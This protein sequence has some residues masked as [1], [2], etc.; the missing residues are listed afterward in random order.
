MKTFL[1]HIKNSIQYPLYDW[2]I[3][4]ILGIIIFLISLLNKISLKNPLLSYSLFIISEVLL[5][6]EMGYG[7]KIVY[8]GI[9]GENKPPLFDKYLN[10]I[11]EGFRKTCIFLTYTSALAFL[12]REAMTIVWTDNSNLILKIVCCLAYCLIYL[13]LIGSI[14]NRYEHNGKFITAFN[15]KEIYEL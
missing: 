14:L 2:R 10:L 9:K 8:T 4:L 6:T 1:R 13:I 7:S 15:F 3:L 12:H 11:W 5:F